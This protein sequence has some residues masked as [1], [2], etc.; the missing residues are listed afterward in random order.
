ML[1]RV[2]LILALGILL[3]VI[4]TV[5]KFAYYV[6]ANSGP[7]NSS[8]GQPPTAC[9]VQTAKHDCGKLNC[10]S[11]VWYCDSHGSPI[12]DEGRCRCFYGCL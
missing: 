5:A 8:G 4:G 3:W 10:I 9:A 11:H 7:L 2:L 1:K 6:H 12:C